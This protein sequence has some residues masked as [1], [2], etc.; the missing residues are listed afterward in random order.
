MSFRE[1]VEKT[2]GLENAYQIGLQALRARD[3]PHVDPE[4]PRGLTGSVDIDTAFQQSDP[5]ANR[6]D[7]GVAYKHSNRANDVIYWLE[8]HTANDSE[9]K[10]VIKKA[11][12]L[13]GW[14]NG[15]GMPLSTFERDIVWVS[16]GP[17][18]ITLSAPQRKQMAQVGL[19]YIGRALRIPTRRANLDCYQRFYC[20]VVP[21]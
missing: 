13:R 19:R 10:V 2:P 4:D 16:S 21:A 3:K 1:A 8:L 17:T 12:W 15:I 11:L 9:I 14:L 6:W 5:Q 20:T 7:F 18:S